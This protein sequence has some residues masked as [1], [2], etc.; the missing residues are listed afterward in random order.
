MHVSTRSV[1]GTAACCEFVSNQA[2]I[3]TDPSH[4]ALWTHLP[5]W[6]LDWPYKRLRLKSVAEENI[7]RVEESQIK[8]IGMYD[9]LILNLINTFNSIH[10]ISLLHADFS[11]APL[12]LLIIILYYLH[13]MLTDYNHPYPLMTLL[14][15]PHWML[16]DHN[17]P[18]AL[19]II[20]IT[21]IERWHIIT[22]SVIEVDK[23][24][25]ITDVFTFSHSMAIYKLKVCMSPALN[26]NRII[27]ALVCQLEYTIFHYEIGQ[28][29]S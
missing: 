1:S 16:T 12:I 11:R 22:T 18:C 13:W 5:R 20:F 9:E 10:K 27:F 29:G 17:H 14:H 21:R 19:I 15:Y 3:D 26:N 25:P 2:N 6:P 28:R 4:A 7:A 23:K 8:D 24:S